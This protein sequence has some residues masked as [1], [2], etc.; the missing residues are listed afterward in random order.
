MTLRLVKP[1]PGHV[2]EW[3]RWRADPVSRRVMQLPGGDLDKWA[4]RLALALSDLSDRSGES[5][6]WI[7]EVEGTPV[8]SVSFHFV[9]WNHLACEIGYVIAPE[10]RGM[11]LGR[12]MVASGLDL[13]FA[14]GLERIMAFICTDNAASI[15]LVED[16]GFRREGLLRRHA[17]IEGERRD[18]Y[19]H[20]LL[21]EEWRPAVP[22]S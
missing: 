2:E 9:D 17:V 13:G 5:Y 6:R 8:G 3:R 18:H 4:K 12:Q 14:G 16:L 10:R 22:R 1:Q 20:A 21:K 11:G 15:R 7:G 19:L